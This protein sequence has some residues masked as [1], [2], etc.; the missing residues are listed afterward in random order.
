MTTDTVQDTNKFS[1]DGTGTIAAEQQSINGCLIHPKY[2]VWADGV[3]KRL[4]RSGTE[5]NPLPIP[6]VN[7]PCPTNYKWSGHLAEIC[8]RPCY[9]SSLGERTSNGAIVIGLTFRSFDGTTRVWKTIWADNYQLSSSKEVL[10]LA[11]SFFPVRS[12][13][14]NQM[15]EY[16]TDCV[17]A[18][19]GLMQTRDVVARTGWHRLRD[20]SQGWL[21]GKRWVGRGSVSICPDTANPFTSA[22]T[23]GTG[24][25]EEWVTTTRALWETDDSWIIRWMLGVACASPLL[26][27]VKER[28]FFVHHYTQSG[29]GKTTLAQLGQ[30]IWAHPK[31]FGGA[32]NQETDVTLLETFKYVSDVPV[33]YDELQ[34]L[35]K[36]ISLADI[37]MRITTEKHKQRG[38]QSGGLQESSQEQPWRTIVRTTGEETLVGSQGM[39]DLGG[40][41]NRVIEVNHPGIPKEKGMWIFKNLLERPKHYG[42]AGLKYLQHLSDII[43]EEGGQ[44]RMDSIF[45]LS[46]QEIKKYVRN[47]G[48]EEDTLAVDRQL[49]VI[50]MG[51]RF[52][53]EWIYGFSRKEAT[54]IALED[55]VKIGR[56]HM[57]LKQYGLPMWRQAVDAVLNHRIMFPE[58]YIDISTDTGL[59]RFMEMGAPGA[60]PIYGV[61]NAGDD[62]SETWYVKKAFYD[63]IKEQMGGINADGVLEQFAKQQIIYP[64][65]D[66]FDH[67][68]TVKRKTVPVLLFDL[69]RLQHPYEECA[70]PE[71]SS[72]LSEELDAV[73]GEEVSGAAPSTPV[74]DEGGHTV[75]APM[76]GLS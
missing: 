17:S 21:I 61:N 54:Q 10:E 12:A 62:R 76:V 71:M 41:G 73:L 40:Q 58:C 34:G 32:L 45:A 35:N 39:V 18:N 42:F 15:S 22:L 13:N 74:R 52:M 9:V 24:S 25:L 4:K 11:R 64:A 50:L 26:R 37:I 3:Y 72:Q 46:T 1:P 75:E 14:Q 19:L 70:Y 2:E 49:A 23:T 27:L 44:E 5:E 63:L 43:S 65:R 69:E 28:T 53:L 68:R 66:R 16:L 6:D 57:R 20:G 31:G 47:A 30:A 56:N 38:K 55:C 36:N 59:N 29:G 60:K 8:D 48:P 7:K 51:E 67:K 33:L